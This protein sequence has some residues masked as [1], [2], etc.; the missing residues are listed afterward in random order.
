MRALNCRIKNASNTLQRILQVLQ[1]LTLEEEEEDCERL[2]KYSRYSQAMGKLE[3][4][5]PGSEA[6]ASRGAG[7]VRVLDSVPAVPCQAGHCRCAEGIQ[8]NWVPPA[9]SS[10]HSGRSRRTLQVGHCRNLLNCL[11]RAAPS[12]RKGWPSASFQGPGAEA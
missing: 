10:D 2:R 1:G 9:L 7:W 3:L 4:P 11:P 6:P 5:Y 12:V 8:A